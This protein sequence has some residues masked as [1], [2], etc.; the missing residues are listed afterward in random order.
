MAI[1]RHADIA[2]GDGAY[3]A[4]HIELWPDDGGATIAVFLTFQRHVVQGMT[5]SGFT[6]SAEVPGYGPNVVLVG[7]EQMLAQQG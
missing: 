3:A 2:S 1:G 4:A 7:L 6:G 5:T